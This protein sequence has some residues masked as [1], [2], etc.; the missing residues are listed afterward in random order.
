MK[1]IPLNTM[2][3]MVIIEVI[4]WT[5]LVFYLENSLW[6]FDDLEHSIK[7]NKGALSGSEEKQ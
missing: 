6:A 7:T 3:E 2:D 1:N 5:R 4:Y